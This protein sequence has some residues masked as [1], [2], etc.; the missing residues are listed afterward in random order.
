MKTVANF[1]IYTARKEPQRC[2]IRKGLDAV[3]DAR[4][5]LDILMPV[6]IDVHLCESAWSSQK[7]TKG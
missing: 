3:E 4:P 1:A 2:E 7:H 6:G 5:E